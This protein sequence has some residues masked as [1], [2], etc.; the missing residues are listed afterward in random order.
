MK[1]FLDQKE[2]ATKK[3]VALTTA[4]TLGGLQP[5]GQTETFGAVFPT[6][7]SISHKL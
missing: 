5:K 7:I 3:N 4:K 1:H 6:V 2:A